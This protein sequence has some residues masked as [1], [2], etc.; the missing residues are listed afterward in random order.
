[1]ISLNKFE[2][3]EFSHSNLRLFKLNTNYKKASKYLKSI[4]FITI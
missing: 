4:F 2:N 3:K 1:M